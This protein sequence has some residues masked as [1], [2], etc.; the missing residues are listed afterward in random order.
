M[1]T[2]LEEVACVQLKQDCVTGLNMFKVMDLF[3]CI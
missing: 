3:F 2:P 1:V